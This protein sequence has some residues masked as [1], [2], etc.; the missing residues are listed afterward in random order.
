M[1]NVRCCVRTATTVDVCQS[2][3]RHNIETHDDV[4]RWKH[5]PRNWPFVRE[6]TKKASDAELWCFLWS[7]P[8]INGWVN[9]F[10]A[11][12]LRRHCAHYEVIV[13]LS[14]SLAFQ[15]WESIG[16]WRIP[17]TKSQKWG[18]LMLLR[19][20]REQTNKLL[21]KQPVFWDAWRSCDVTVRIQV[22]WMRSMTKWRTRRFG[23]T[24]YVFPCDLAKSRRHGIRN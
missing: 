12:D 10:E 7:A 14:A 13:M 22:F 11:G 9:N 17:L 23:T 8:W 24:E 5:F 2:W 6:F 1:I 20:M 19:Y 4:I 18:T 3:R 21:N 15:Y 16:H